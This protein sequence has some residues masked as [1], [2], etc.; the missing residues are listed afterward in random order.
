LFA[1]TEKRGELRASQLGG[2]ADLR[3][4]LGE[5]GGIISAS[6]LPSTS[7]IVRNG[8]PSCSSIEWTVTMFGCVSAATAR[9]SR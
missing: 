8:E 1:L 9:A 3:W 2:T 5:L 6:V 4:R 7:S